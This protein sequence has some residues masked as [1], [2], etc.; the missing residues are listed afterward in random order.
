MVRSLWSAASGMI[1]E[2]TNIDTISHNLSN[3]NTTGYKTEVANFKSLLY[4]TLQTRTT[5]AT[6]EEKPVGA[7]VG[8]GTRNTSISSEFAQGAFRDTESN[9]DFALSGTGFFAVQGPNDRILYTRNGNFYLNTNAQGGLTLCS[10]EGYPVLDTTGK[11]ITFSNQYTT[12]NLVVSED[13]AF[14]YPDNKGVPQAL[15]IQIGVWQFN[16]PQGL[17]KVGGSF[18]TESVAS[19]TPINESNSTNVEKSRI[20]QGYLEQSTVQVVDEMVNMIIAQRAYEMNAKAI[21]TSDEMLQTA[22]NLKR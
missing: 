14:F 4:Q 6:N 10:S 19:G 2:Q 12:S 16:N 18:F 5:A 15:N 20:V 7:Q 11:A 21:T 9:T 8:L 1:A 13:G 22:N 17:N 3:V